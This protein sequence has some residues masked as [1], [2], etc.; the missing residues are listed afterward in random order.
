MFYADENPTT[1]YEWIVDKYASN[2]AFKV[3]AI[4]SHD[5]Y[6]LVGK[7]GVKKFELT[8]SAVPS[9]GTFRIAYARSW[10]FGGFESPDWQSQ[11]IMGYEFGID[12][13]CGDASPD[14]TTTPTEPVVPEKPMC[15]MSMCPEGFYR[16]DWT[17]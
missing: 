11:S 5:R 3:N 16:D 8:T 7:G 4:Y 10:E 2:H 17:C 6:G 1:G 13:S 9:S 15:I 12:V 14:H